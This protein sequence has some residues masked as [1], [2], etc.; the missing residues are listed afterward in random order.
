MRRR[1]QSP[2]QDFPNVLLVASTRFLEDLESHQPR[3]DQDVLGDPEKNRQAES[4]L[5]SGPGRP[6]G[7]TANEPWKDAQI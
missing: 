5:T 7:P 6:G 2:L 3:Q 1:S 4:R